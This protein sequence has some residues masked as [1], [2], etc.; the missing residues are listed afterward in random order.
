[1]SQPMLAVTAVSCRFPGA[2]N[3]AEFWRLLAEG[4]E[5]LTRFSE[6]ELDRAGV[7]RSLR[8]HPAYVPVGG[9]IDG[10]DLF[11]PEAFGLT[12]HEAALLDPQQRLFLECCWHALESAGHG[13][14]VGAGEVGVFAGAAHSSY[15]MSNLAHRYS[16]VGGGADPVGSLQT[17]MGT[18]ADYLPLHVAH[19]LDL[20]GPAVAVNST[21]STSLVAV[22]LAA[23][24]LLA[25]ECD[26]ALAG[27]VSLTVPQ[28]HGYLHVP[29]AMFSADGKVRAFSADGTGIVFGQGVGVAVLRRLDDALADGDPVLAVLLGSAVNNDGASKVGF[30]A[31]SMTGQARV[32]AEA[33]AVAGVDPR[34]IGY[35]EAHGTGTRLGD[36]IEVAALRKVFGGGPAWCGLGSVKSNIGH[37]NS[38]AGI[39]GFI[40]AVLA[41]EHELIPPTLHAKPVNP[42]LALDGSAFDLVTEPRPWPGVRRAGVSSFGIGGTNAHVVVGSPPVRAPSASDD[43]PQLIVVSAHSERALS[44][45]AAALAGSAAEAPGDISYTLRVGRRPHRHRLATVVDSADGLGRLTAVPTTVAADIAPRVIFA[46]P[47]GGSQYPGMGAQTYRTERVFAEVVDEQA[48]LLAP[49]LGA[50]IRRVVLDPDAAEPARDPSVGLPALFV[51]CL[52][53]A[54]LLRSWGIT[55]DV[56]LGH[57]LGEYTAATVAGVFSPAEAA[58]V[59]A[60]RSIGMAE[61]A[62]DGAMLAV[63]ANVSLVRAVLSAHPMV[64]LAVIN[65]D[66]ACVV[67]GPR[68]DITRLAADLAG[69][70]I[71]TEPLVLDAAA[72]S[73]LVEPAIPALRAALERIRPR[74]PEVPVASTLTGRLAEAELADPGHWVS[75]LRSTVDFPGALR[76]AVD[77]GPAVLIQVGPGAGLATLARRHALPGLLDT[78]AGFPIRSG[79]GTERKALLDAVASLWGHGAS[80]D[81][82]AIDDRKRTRVALPDYA[83]DRRRCWIDPPERVVTGPTVEE[84]L[85]V[86]TWRRVEPLANQAPLEGRWLVVGD[87]LGTVSAAL[88]MRGAETVGLS[89]VGDRPCDGVVSLLGARRDGD[90]AEHVEELL[91]ETGRVA[92]AVAGL[93]RPPRYWVQVTAGGQQVESSDRPDPAVAA[94]LALPRVLAQEMPGLRWRSIDLDRF[95]EG[96]GESVADEVADLTRSG[97][98]AEEIATRGSVRWQRGM[99]PWRP[100]AEAVT[101]LGVVLVIG[102]TGDVG[103]VMAEHL[104]SVH[105][106]TVVLTSRTASGERA[107]RVDE[108]SARGLAVSLC[109][110]DA[111][112]RAATERLL[113]ELVARHGQVDLVVHAAGVVA[114]TGVGP[115]RTLGQEVA[116][117]HVRAKVRSALVLED[118]LATLPAS[119]RPK[120]VLL[121][122]SATT[123]VGGLG[124]GPYAAANRFLDAMAERRP[125]TGTTWFSVAWDGWRVGPDGGERTVAI[126]HSLGAQDGMR[127]LDRLLAAAF[128]RGVPSV[129]GVSPSDLSERMSGPAT[130]ADAEPAVPGVPDDS[131]DTLL[132]LWS[133]VLGFEVRDRNADFFALGGHSLLATA[134]LARLRDD[135]DVDLRLSDLLAHSTVAR[136]APLVAARPAPNSPPVKVPAPREQVRQDGAFPLSPVQRAYWVGRNNAELGGVACHFF[137]E[138]DCPELDLGRYQAAWRKVIDRHPMLRTVVTPDGHNLTFDSVPPYRIRRHDLRHVDAPERER[139]LAVLRDRIAHHVPRHDRWPLIEI[140]A[141]ALPGGGTRLFIGV[142]VLVCDVASYLIVDREV[143]RFYTDPDGRLPEPGLTFADYLAEADSAVSDADRDRASRYWRARLAGLPAAPV[144]PTAVRPGAAKFHRLAARLAPEQWE[145]LKRRAGDIGV[146]PTAVLLTAY[147]EALGEWSGTPRFALTLTRYERQQVHPDVNRV[148]GDFTTLQIHEIDHATAG[149]FADRARATQQRLFA[150]LDHGAFSGLDV[151]AEKSVLDGR[152]YLVPVVFTGAVGVEDVLGQ[153][154]DL[155]WVGEQVHAVSQTP[156]VVLDHQVYVQRGALLVQ[157]DVLESEVDIAEAGPVFDRYLRR[158]REL[159]VSPWASSETVTVPDSAVV[160]QQGVTPPLFL[161]HPSGGDVLCYAELARLLGTDRSVIALTDPELAGLAAPE[162]MPALVR[163]YSDAI[164]A[165]EPAGPYRLGG[166]SMGGTV[167]HQVAVELT[168]AGHEVELVVMIDSNLP[169]HITPVEPSAHGDVDGEVCLRFLRSLE[170]SLEIDLGATAHLASLERGARRAE[171]IRRLRAHGLVGARGDGSTVDLRLSVFARHLR[172]LAD[173]V[174]HHLP[175]RTKVLVFRAISRSPRNSGIGMGVDDVAGVA[176][177][178]WAPYVAGRLDV[179]DV[180]AHHYSVLRE[181]AVG[182][183]AARIRSELGNRHV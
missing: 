169:D 44:A 12:A 2:G 162:D 72:H 107:R 151:L 121:M 40:K 108:L 106:A 32:I 19:R 165:C 64:D 16:A 137:L 126:W 115:L 67:A 50:D 152:P 179:V 147:A 49:L 183:I 133:D 145:A 93:P 22:H 21:C 60:A 112:D 33:L 130:V 144:L 122:S 114:S 76:A 63:T 91:L 75:Q 74:S 88:A 39:A 131:E 101:G 174:A 14:G 124:L 143:Q 30:T 52:A 13:H 25:G 26:T 132:A 177:L 41:I 155:D 128:R 46:F 138:Y 69:R 10:Q 56:L 153:P 24:S 65:T 51:V 83:F 159:A 94:V 163:H 11:D 34:E 161:L 129:V 53:E 9:L 71:S 142:D 111:S 58:E 57:S 96:H 170:A 29:D 146:T 172:M 3:T 61:A 20:R 178:G 62:G 181:P 175:S 97:W 42:E 31:P 117:A 18:V 70:G 36:P 156:Q 89:G 103:L 27:G 160:F 86:P 1:M 140:Q 7:A 35:V 77:D 5:G 149:D 6:A 68:R 78:V 150:D 120:A 23:Q 180:D 164:R 123:L 127:S 176:D 37:A 87:G 15:L 59:V 136:L 141:A 82:A 154:H 119:A 79:P 148:V 38:A 66:D 45:A 166:W 113:N 84:P 80:V 105:G 99:M 47:G 73:R 134:M 109:Q 167:A 17:A 135:H 4:R 43:G 125:D 116:E 28:G 104:A 100:A 158:L 182:T 92:E 55:P 90:E 139:K 8:D 118:A 168:K 157:W 173:H 85:Q 81:L 110:V 171:I 48:E 102:G 98:R 54:A 95:G